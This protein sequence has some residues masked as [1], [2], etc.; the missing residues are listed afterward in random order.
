MAHRRVTQADVAQRAGVSQTAVSQILGDSENEINF[1]PETREKVL[2][3]AKELGYVPSVAA[4]ALRTNR[5]MTI[6]VILGFI[7]DELSLRITRG[8]QDVAQERGYGILIADTEQSGE[9]EAQALEQLRQR[10]VDGLLFVDSWTDPDT[11]LENDLYPPMIFAQLR[12]SI[13]KQNCVGLD[14]FRGGYE[15][16]RHLLD[17]GYRKVAHISGPEKWASAA[18]RFKGYQKAL[19]DRDLPYDPSLVEFCD[20]EVSSGRDATALLLDRHP[21]IDAIFASNDLMAAGS[22]QAAAQRGLRIPQD[23]AL[24][25]Y[26]DRY[27]SEALLPPLTS[28]A[29][30]LNQIGQKAASLLINRLLKKNATRIPSTSLA[31]QVIVRSSCGALLLQNET[32]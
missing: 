9:L 20:W 13:E 1:R 22:I 11:C 8:I 27:L 2:Q 19:A 18:E 16:T 28:Y 5:T 12:Q 10:E 3:A 4:R 26:D 7:T 31:G 25:G 6:G 30:P 15:A 14:N 29:I 17:L 24:I 21:D 32:Q 23:I